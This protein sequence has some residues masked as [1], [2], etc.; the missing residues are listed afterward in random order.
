MNNERSVQ[1]LGSFDSDCRTL[2][3]G[4]LGDHDSLEEVLWRAFSEWG[5]PEVCVLEAL[6]CLGG[7]CRG[8]TCCSVLKTPSL[9]NINLIKRLNIAFVRYPNRL[10]AE[11]AKAAMADQVGALQQ[12]E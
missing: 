7:V 11:F 8:S 9:Q 6:K 3:V 12:Q 5:V 2:Y 10:N 1:C 4:G